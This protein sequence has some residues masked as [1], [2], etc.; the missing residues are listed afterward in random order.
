MIL[1]PILCDIKLWFALLEALNI[2]D[3]QSPKSHILLTVHIKIS[4]ISYCGYYVNSSI[5]LKIVKNHI[6]INN[7]IAKRKCEVI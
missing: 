3:L 5:I 4:F 6:L 2:D 1:Y 7:L